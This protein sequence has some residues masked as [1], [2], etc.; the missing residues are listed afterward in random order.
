[1]WYDLWSASNL[2]G[3]LAWSGGVRLCLFQNLIIDVAMNMFF[4]DR[5]EDASGFL[6]YEECLGFE[7]HVKRL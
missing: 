4:I 1:M 3:M 7:R 2:D 5:F 6:M